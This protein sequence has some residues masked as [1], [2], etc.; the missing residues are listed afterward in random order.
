MLQ[1]EHV[2]ML[3]LQ[4]R[5]MNMR[6]IIN[7]AHRHMRVM[8]FRVGNYEDKREELD[9][10]AHKDGL[11]KAFILVEKQDSHNWRGVGFIRE[12]VYPSF[13]RTADAYVMSRLYDKGGAP[14]QDVSPLKPSSEEKTSF[15]ARR[16]R[17]PDGMK[18]ERLDNERSKS[19]VIE[20]LNGELRA[21]PFGRAEVPDLVLHAKARKREAWVMAEI[22]DS[23]GHATVGVAPAPCSDPELVLAAFACNNL[24]ED[25]ER[26]GVTNLF[27]LSPASDG[28][29]NELYAGLGFKVTGRLAN[30]LR[31]NGDNTTALI[32]HRRL[33]QPRS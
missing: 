33:S 25:L 21:L 32:W 2:E 13:F 9:L 15:P 8:D 30:H 1:P 16:L 10:L 27:G 23:F 17:K 19:S 28:L 26:R 11:R 22:D 24:I 5:D 31:V 12:G 29:N 7:H 20:G 4:H 14:L 6:L 18:V 3:Q